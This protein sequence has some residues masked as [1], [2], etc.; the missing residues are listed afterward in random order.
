IGT[1]YSLSPDFN[2][3]TGFTEEEVRKMLDYYR[4]VLPFNHTTDELIKV[5]KPWYDNY[6]FAEERYGETTMYNSVMVL[7]F[8]DN[9]IRSNYQI[10]KK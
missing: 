9:Y 5:M 10:P 2:E 8:V 7:N 3:M 4:S 6:C 1:N